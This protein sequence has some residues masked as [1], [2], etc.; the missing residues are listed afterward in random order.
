MASLNCFE[1]SA[2]VWAPYHY[3]GFNPTTWATLGLIWPLL[4]L[5]YN[6]YFTFVK[7]FLMVGGVR[8]ELTTP[9]FQGAADTPPVPPIK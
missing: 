7:Y 6:H 3:I 8:V 4:W 2:S 9:R 5:Y 1:A